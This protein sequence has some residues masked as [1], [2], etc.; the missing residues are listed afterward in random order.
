MQYFIF[1]ILLLEWNLIFSQKV[2]VVLSGG[3]AKGLA[4]P[5]VLKALQENDIPIDFI[6]GTSM[7][8]LVGAFYAAGYSTEE[9]VE[10]ATSA[11]LQN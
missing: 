6:A 9:I 5:G 10:L 4:H 2:A 1:I 8:A 3:G 7:G 11:E